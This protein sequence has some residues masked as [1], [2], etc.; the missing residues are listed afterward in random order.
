MSGQVMDDGEIW[1]R[2]SPIKV[3]VVEDGH[4]RMGRNLVSMHGHSFGIYG[5]YTVNIETLRDGEADL[6]T[7]PQQIT[8][9]K[10]SS[11]YAPF[12]RYYGSPIFDFV[13][14]IG[15]TETV[16]AGPYE[17]VYFE[18]EED[19]GK[20]TTLVGDDKNIGYSFF[21]VDIPICVYGIY[22]PRFDMID[23]SEEDYKA[24]LQSI[25][26][27]TE[28]YNGEAFVELDPACDWNYDNFLERY[29]HHEGRLFW[30]TDFK[31][32]SIG[33]ISVIYPE[34][35]EEDP[36]FMTTWPL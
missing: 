35:D 28:P 7:L 14:N 29:T 5:D 18:T 26:A 21:C 27:S 19:V 16:Q 6:E 9:E 1:W 32:T 34:E 12:Y 8:E 23:I 3:P 25:V 22:N 36:A 20:R 13:D 17:A 30:C 31:G 11:E 15:R 2:E 10:D 4:P 24:M 33:D